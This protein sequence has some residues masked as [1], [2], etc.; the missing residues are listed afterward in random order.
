MQR[1]VDNWLKDT[2]FPLE[3]RVAKRLQELEDTGNWSIQA[4]YSYLDGRTESIR[5]IDLLGYVTSRYDDRVVVV[6][7]EIVLECK[8]TANPWV[9]LQ[10]SFKRQP[11]YPV[12]NYEDYS[13]CLTVMNQQAPRQLSR[14]TEALANHLAG[15]LPLAP[16]PGYSVIEAFKN[17]R[18]KDAAYSATRQVINATQHRM[19]VIRKIR[20][21][22]RNVATS[23]QGR[24]IVALSKYVQRATMAT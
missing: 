18:D 7:I 11:M 4:N 9:I 5:E 12:V 3:M 14:F 6:D 17:S 1:R 15:C 22:T 10:E 21:L 24:Y 20:R 16:P 23:L 2:G 8:A 19:E 13:G